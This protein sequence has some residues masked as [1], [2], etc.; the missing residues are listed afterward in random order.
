[1]DLDVLM[2]TWVVQLTSTVVLQPL[3]NHISFASHLFLICN[4]GEGGHHR[5]LHPYDRRQS[6]AECKGLVSEPPLYANQTNPLY[7]LVSFLEANNDM[8]FSALQMLEVISEGL[9]VYLNSSKCS[10]QDNMP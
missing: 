2:R 3:A 1:M 6:L 5:F 9:A 4:A 8:A 7:P 10:A